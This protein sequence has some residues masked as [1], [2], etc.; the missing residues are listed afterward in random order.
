MPLKRSSSHGLSEKDLVK[1]I[2]EDLKNGVPYESQHGYNYK[3]L[4]EAG[5]LDSKCSQNLSKS[6]YAAVS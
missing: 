1:S 6:G 4:N 5:L 2:Q 3:V